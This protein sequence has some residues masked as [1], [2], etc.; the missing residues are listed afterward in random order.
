[1]TSDDL[2]ARL[3]R[4]LADNAR[5]FD[6]EGVRLVERLLDANLVS[7]AH[8]RLVRIEQGLAEARRSAQEAIALLERSPSPPVATVRSAV[9]TGDYGTARRAAAKAT[10][11]LLRRRTSAVVAWANTV[12]ERARAKHTPLPPPVAARPRPG[13]DLPSTPFLDGVDDDPRTATQ[14]LSQ[15]LFDRSIASARASLALARAES[16]VPGDAGPYNPHAIAARALVALGER[17]PDLAL[18]YVEL[19]DELATIE[20]WESSLPPSPQGRGPRLDAPRKPTRVR[21]RQSTSSRGRSPEGG[22]T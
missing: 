11:A 4:L 2:R 7:R 14:R 17:A 19:L 16:G 22:S 21:A 20:H 5:G 9:A 12:A 18:A 6:P 8:E 13:L 15:T 10:A 3:E 1:M